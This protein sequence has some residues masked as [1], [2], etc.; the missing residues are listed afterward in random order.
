MVRSMICHSSL[1]KPL[2]G[3]ALKTIVYILNKVPS[4]SIAKTPY[5]LWIGKKPS[6]M[7]LTCLGLS[8]SGMVL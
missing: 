6:I 3:K 2:W 8:S 7:T 1:P 5:E 4:K